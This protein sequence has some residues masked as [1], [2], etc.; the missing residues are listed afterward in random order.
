MAVT[1]CDHICWRIRQAEV[2]QFHILLISVIRPSTKGPQ[3]MAIFSAPELFRRW[4]EV[5]ARLDGEECY[6]ALSFHNSYY[7]SGLPMQQW[8]RF[9]RSEEHTSE[10][11]SRGH[12]VCR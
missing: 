9:S 10:L 3:N 2:D 1:V 4:N 6:I 5:L 11:Q 8:G 12:L 7:L